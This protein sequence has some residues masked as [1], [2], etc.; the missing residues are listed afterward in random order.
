MNMTT[1]LKRMW[2]QIMRVNTGRIHFDSTI[3]GNFAYLSHASCLYSFSLPCLF[4]I[5]EF[6]CSPWKVLFFGIS[7]IDNLLVFNC[8]RENSGCV[9]S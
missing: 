9:V 2:T 4:K 7:S 8:S 1:L 6:L 5:Y 3:I